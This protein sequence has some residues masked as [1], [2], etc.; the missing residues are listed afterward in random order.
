M[1]SPPRIATIHRTGPPISSPI[2]VRREVCII[3]IAAEQVASNAPTLR[4]MWRQTMM[5]TIPVA[6]IATDTVW[7]VRLKI[8]RGVRKR[9][10]VSRSNTMHSSTNAPIIPSR[11][12][13]S[14]SDANV[15]FRAGRGASVSVVMDSSPQDGKKAPG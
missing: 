5:N 1:T 15:L 3:A 13:S 6:M 7:I 11:R 2:C 14:S 4:S 10:P 8:L 9:P 12:V